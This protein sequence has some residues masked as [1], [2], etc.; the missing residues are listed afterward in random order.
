[1][2]ECLRRRLSESIALREGSARVALDF[3]IGVV[4]S[5]KNGE[6]DT[7]VWLF[8]YLNQSK[9]HTAIIGLLKL[10][11]ASSAKMPMLA[12]INPNPTR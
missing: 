11:A 12:L 6:H 9:T 10:S 4:I 1:M 2:L 3:I 8:M 5:Q 7:A